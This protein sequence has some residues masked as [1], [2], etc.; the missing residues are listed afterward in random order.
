MHDKCVVQTGSEALG[1]FQN[2]SLFTDRTVRCAC[3]LDVVR[4]GG[5]WF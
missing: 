2:K 1:T 3:L 4:E 5:D